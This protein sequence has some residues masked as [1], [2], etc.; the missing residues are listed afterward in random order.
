MTST[1][2]TND[3]E[4]LALSF[5]KRFTGENKYNDW[6]MDA[7]IKELDVF[8]KGYLSEKKQYDWWMNAKFIENP[9]NNKEAWFNAFWK[10]EHSENSLYA[11]G[12]KTQQNQFTA[13]EKAILM[14]LPES[15]MTEKEQNKVL[16]KIQTHKNKVF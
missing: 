6:C 16:K 5:Y 15:G 13:M 2:C 14:W 9:K 11:K 12:M 4:Q 8:V 1:Y 7:A 3:Y 10:A